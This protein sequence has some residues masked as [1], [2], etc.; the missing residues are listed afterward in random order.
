[1]VNRPVFLSGSATS[2]RTVKYATSQP[3]EYM[4]PSYP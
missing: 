2:S 1:M 4:N 3:T